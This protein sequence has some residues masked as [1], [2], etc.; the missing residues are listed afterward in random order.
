MTS[1]GPEMP[2]FSELGPGIRRLVAP[3]PSLMTGPGTNTYLFGTDEIA[4]LDPGPLIDEHID[5][6]QQVAG[7]PI[8][9]VL[10]TH[11]HED[12]SPAAAA[13]ADLPPDPRAG[14]PV[15]DAGLRAPPAPTG[16]PRSVG[17]RRH[18]LRLTADP[19]SVVRRALE[20][21]GRA[22]GDSL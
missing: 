5:E 21:P 22:D 11:T 14:A 6:I 20:G 15:G 4:V 7:A 16:R 3:N 12:H 13:L 19:P 1:F 9:W 8:R 2:S 10:V 17:R 18:R